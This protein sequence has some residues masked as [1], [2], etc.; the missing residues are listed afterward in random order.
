[1]SPPTHPPRQDDSPTVATMSMGNKFAHKAEAVKG[2]VKRT[3]GPARWQPSPAR[4]GPP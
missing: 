4:R 1:M 3:A 2:S